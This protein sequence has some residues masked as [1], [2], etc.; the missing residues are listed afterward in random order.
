MLVETGAFEAPPLVIVAGRNNI[1]KRTLLL[2]WLCA[3]IARS[4][5]PVRWFDASAHQTSKFLDEKIGILLGRRGA[6]LLAQ[7]TAAGIAARWAVKALILLAYPSKWRYFSNVFLGRRHDLSREL[8]AFIRSCSGNRIYLLSN[9]AGCIAACKVEDEPAVTAQICIGYP[10]RHP[11]RGE[12]GYR[13]A[14]LAGL[15]KPLVIIQGSDD[16]YGNSEDA[17]RYPLS[18]MVRLVSVEGG[19]D[20]DELAETTYER[21]LALTAAFIGFECPRDARSVVGHERGA[22]VGP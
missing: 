17:K 21:I 15:R 6:G 11:E 2:E 10:F 20:Y 12:E 14:A 8:R 18:P 7:R 1:K 4:G 5:I 9:S 19:H 3:D 13:T 22:A 16:C